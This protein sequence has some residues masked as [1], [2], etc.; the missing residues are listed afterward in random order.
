MLLK[1]GNVLR[2]ITRNL[3]QCLK[4]WYPTFINNKKK[5]ENMLK[6]NHL[7]VLEYIN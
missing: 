3:T 5:K 1:L 7:Y 6:A 2:F 4:Y